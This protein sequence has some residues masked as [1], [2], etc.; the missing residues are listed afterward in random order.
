MFYLFRHHAVNFYFFYVALFLSILYLSGLNM[1]LKVKPRPDIS[2][3]IYLWGFPVQQT[4]AWMYPGQSVPVNQVASILIAILL[5]LM[6]W[7]LLEKHCIDLGRQITQK[8]RDMLAC[9][10]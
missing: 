6:S 7:H 3:G 9:S 1:L 4:I 8:R 2:Y 10:G 5:G